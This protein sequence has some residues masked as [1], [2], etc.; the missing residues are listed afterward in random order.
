MVKKEGLLRTLD[1]LIRNYTLQVKLDKVA[2]YKGELL[3]INP[4]A[5]FY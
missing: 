5:Y 4:N 3:K 1:L 2:E